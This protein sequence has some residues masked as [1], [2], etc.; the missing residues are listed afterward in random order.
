MDG[1]V[2]DDVEELV[3]CELCPADLH[4][5]LRPGGYARA[6]FGMV[7]HAPRRNVSQT[8]LYIAKFVE[9]VDEQLV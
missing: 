7:Q 6:D 9:F 4:S 8:L 5:A 1:E 3:E 2:I